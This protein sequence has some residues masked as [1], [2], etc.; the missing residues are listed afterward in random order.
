MAETETTREEIAAR[1][2]AGAQEIRHIEHQLGELTD[3]EREIRRERAE[4][5]EKLNAAR[6]TQTKDLFEADNIGM[7]RQ[8]IVSLSGISKSTA[9]RRFGGGGK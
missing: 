7:P 8:M 6:E 2:L 5:T 4:W 3:K 9:L 1:L